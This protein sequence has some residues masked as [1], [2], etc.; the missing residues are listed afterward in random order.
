ML[1]D[2]SG[3]ESKI[4]HKLFLSLKRVASS[5]N[6]NDVFKPLSMSYFII[7][8]GWRQKFSDGGLTLPTR[9]LKYGF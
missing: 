7:K 5:K 3:F 8:Q 6:E 9:G 1:L 2:F 4:I